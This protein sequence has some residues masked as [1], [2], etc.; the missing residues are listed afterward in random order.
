MRG[1]CLG[2]GTDIGGSVR[3]PAANCGIYGLRPSNY[4]LPVEGWAA[5]MAGQEQVVGVLGPLSTSLEG[6]KLFMKTVIAAKPWLDEPSL[7]PIPW[8]DQGSQLAT[9]SGK[10]KLKIGVLWHDEVV[11]PHP[12]VLRALQ[13]M[14]D[15]L[16]STD[17]VEIVDWKP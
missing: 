5:T 11:R 12:P 16:K 13:E 10:K 1:S 9:S 6:I 4:K 14:V 3:S 8:R 7:V 15:K 2:L 17:G